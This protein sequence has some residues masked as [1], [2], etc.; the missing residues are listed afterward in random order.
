MTVSPSLVRNRRAFLRIGMLATGVAVLAACGAGATTKSS[1]TDE[2]RARLEALGEEMAAA[3]DD[4][5]ITKIKGSDRQTG[6]VLWYSSAGGFGFIT[7]QSGPDV[8]V[9]R[10]AIVDGS[11]LQEGQIVDY[12]EVAGQKGPQADEVRVR[13]P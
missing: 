12:V 5:K 2:E 1:L 10:R 4:G 11:I 7:S 13:T 9:H 6:T 3:I 8:F